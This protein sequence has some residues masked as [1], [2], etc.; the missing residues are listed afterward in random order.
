MKKMA[1]V[2]YNNHPNEKSIEIKKDERPKYTYTLEEAIEEASECR[3]ICAKYMC[4]RE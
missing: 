4:G 2:I 3:F 1:Q